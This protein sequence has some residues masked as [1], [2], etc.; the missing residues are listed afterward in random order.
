MWIFQTKFTTHTHTSVSHISKSQ[1]HKKKNKGKQNIF[2]IVSVSTIFTISIY[3]TVCV[4]YTPPPTT[5]RKDIHFSLN[6][7][8][9]GVEK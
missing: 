7:I 8:L 9:P 1:I 3:N 6:T 2:K 4:A 5:T